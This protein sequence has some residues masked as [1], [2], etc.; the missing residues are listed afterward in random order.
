MG[1]KGKAEACG[2]C[3]MTTVMDVTTGESGHNPFEGDR[4]EV[5]EDQM[6]RVSPHII[7]LGNFKTRLTQWATRLTYG[8]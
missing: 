5:D 7:A 3:S 6:R 4:I 2:R 8:R 1:T